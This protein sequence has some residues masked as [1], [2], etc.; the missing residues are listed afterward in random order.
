MDIDGEHYVTENDTIN[1]VYKLLINGSSINDENTYIVTAS[2]KIGESSAQ[3][4]FSVHSKSA[5]FLH[6]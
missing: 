3:A 4:R 1:E 5:L 2:N 6:L